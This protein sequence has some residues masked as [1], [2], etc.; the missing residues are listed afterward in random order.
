MEKRVVTTI[1]EEFFPLGKTCHNDSDLENRNKHNKMRYTQFAQG[2][3]VRVLACACVGKPRGCARARVCGHAHVYECPCACGGVSVCVRECT[4]VCAYTRACGCARGWTSTGACAVEDGCVCA[5]ERC[6]CAGLWTRVCAGCT[7]VRVRAYRVCASACVRACA[8]VRACAGVL[9]THL[10]V[11]VTKSS[12]E[13]PFSH[14]PKELPFW[15]QS[16]N[17]GT[18]PEVPC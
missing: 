17:R 16:I 4:R 10:T 18:L 15:S 14:H 9:A 12:T 6:G 7:C 5:R 13:Y 1:H 2:V 11:P 8:R 3:R